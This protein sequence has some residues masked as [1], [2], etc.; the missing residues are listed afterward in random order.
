MGKQ[1]VD[2]TSIMKVL[3]AINLV[4]LPMLAMGQEEERL[5]NTTN[6]SEKQS[7]Y[8]PGQCQEYSVNF[9]RTDDVDLCHKFCGQ[10]E[11]CSWWSFEPSQNLCLLFANCTESGAPDVV[12][13]ED[14]IS[15]EKLCPSRECHGAFKCQ[16]IFIDS[17]EIEHLEDCLEACSDV[18][19][20]MYFTLEKTHNHCIL[21]EGCE[22][23]LECETCATGERECSAG[24]HGPTESPAPIATTAPP[25]TP[26]PCPYGNACVTDD[27]CCADYDPEPLTC[28]EG[29]CEIQ[30]I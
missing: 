26:A 23:Q 8:V 24:Y 6:I 16:D 20:C 13:C 17:F 30:Y 15:G 19:E 3:F 12:A 29:F 22:A 1:S 5:I 18:A 25:T 21:Y 27:D 4:L 10:N 11:D 9:K 2:N 14:C 28:I 7:C